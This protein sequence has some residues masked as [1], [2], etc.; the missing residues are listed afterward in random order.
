MV[1][2]QTQGSFSLSTPFKNKHWLIRT[3]SMLRYSNKNGYTTLNKEEP[4][5]SS[6]RHLTAREDL[7]WTYRTEQFGGGGCEGSVLI[8]NSYNNVRSIR[9][10]TFDYQTGMNVQWYFPL[11]FELY[12]DAVWNLRAGIWHR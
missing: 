10:K 8:I 5:K 2:W 4:Q 3:Y 12:S 11:V 7:L 1:N 6:V 9:T